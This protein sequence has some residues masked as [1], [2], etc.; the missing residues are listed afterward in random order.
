MNL[1]GITELFFR[2][3]GSSRLKEPAKTC[4]CVGKPPRWY[5]NA[6]VIQRAKDYVR[7]R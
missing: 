4:T 5:F 3:G 1:T 6:E 2:G 7:L